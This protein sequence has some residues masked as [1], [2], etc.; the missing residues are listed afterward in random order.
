MTRRNSILLVAV[1]AVAAVGAYWMLVL[2]PKREEAAALDT[3]IAAKQAA[4]AQAEAEVADYERRAPT[5]RPTTRWSPGSAR[6]SP[7]TTT[8]AR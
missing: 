4:L 3:Q 2:A 5:T 7:P 6:P 1:A 8:S